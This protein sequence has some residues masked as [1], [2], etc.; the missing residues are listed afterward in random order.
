MNFSTARPA[1]PLPL[2]AAVLLA[3]LSFVLGGCSQ[4][5][6]DDANAQRY[7]L[8]GTVVSVDRARKIVNVDHE[9]IPGYMAAMRMDFPLKDA[10]A[11]KVV[12]PGDTI[13]ATLVVADTEY[14]L[15]SPAVTKK[16]PGATAAE[17]AGTEPQPGAEVPEVKLVN[18]DGKAVRTGQYRGR[19][20]L[21][22]FIYTR[23]PFADQCPLMSANFAQL[24][25]QLASDPALRAGTRLLSVTLDPEYDKPD[26]LRAYGSTYA[27]GK[28]DNWDFATGDPVEIRK[29]AEGFGLAYK[30]EGGQIVHSLRTALVSPEG[31]LVKI[32]RGN[33][34]KPAD[35]LNDL[36]GLQT[37]K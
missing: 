14:W 4:K 36:R 28:F 23:C 16:L 9:E 29:L 35:V 37:Q 10:D 7:D 8:K 22:T 34:W 5:P 20:L 2:P 27:G 31:R 19:A 13:Q 21:V 18:Q 33:E 6:P 32:Y 24:N 3:A 25:G 30:A 1:R 17:V 26:V 12:E 11:L 15:E